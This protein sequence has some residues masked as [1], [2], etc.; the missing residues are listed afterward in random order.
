[1]TRRRTRA[2]L[3]TAQVAVAML[4]VAGAGLFARSLAAAL[5]LNADLDMSRIVTGGV[6]LVPYG[7]DVPRAN[8]FFDEVQARLRTNPAVRSVAYSVF[9][10]AMGGRLVV[11]AVPRQ[12]PSA[13]W[14]TAVDDSYFRTMGLRMRAGRDFSDGDRP[15]SP[16]VTIV[17]ESFGRQLADGNPIGHRVTMPGQPPDVMEVVG[18]VGDVVGRISVLQPLDM[19]FPVRQTVPS[20]DRTLVVRAAGDA[21]AARRE[22]MGAIKAADPAVAPS[23]L[24]TLEDR[25]GDQMA[26]QRF[27]AVV[28]GT[29][30]GIA[31]LL[32]ILGTYVLGESMAVMRMREMGIRAALGATRRQLGAIVMAETLRLV[33]LGLAV[34]LALAWLAA[35]TIRAFLFQVTPF[36]PVTLI[37]VASLILTLALL[38]SVR[39]ALRAARVDLGSVLKEQ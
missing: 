1:M 7:Y 18:V 9:Q 26:A 3:V 11:D 5:S 6:Y 13:V 19:Y 22:I 20:L 14:F 28:L 17:S 10:G 32:T 23:P 16:M 36:D 15:G 30:G 27:G 29:L 33:G 34:G 25:I 39:P 31:V 12:F 37:A 4:L 8:V 21:R 35:S 38:V 24:V 2:A